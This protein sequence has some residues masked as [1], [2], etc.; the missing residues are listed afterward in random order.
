MLGSVAI[1]FVVVWITVSGLEIRVLFFGFLV[2]GNGILIFRNRFFVLSSGWS[3]SHSS[4]RLVGRLLPAVPGVRDGCVAVWE[5]IET[6][7][8]HVSP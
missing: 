7:R 4:I 8:G 2:Y 6:V 3:R 1:F 5:H